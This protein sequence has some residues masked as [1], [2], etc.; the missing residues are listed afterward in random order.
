MRADGGDRFAADH[1]EAGDD[2][3]RADGARIGNR[4]SSTTVASTS[5]TSAAHDGWIT[6]A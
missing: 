4:S 3:Q 1:H 5:P 6:P 2:D